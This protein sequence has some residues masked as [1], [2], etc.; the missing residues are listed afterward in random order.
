MSKYYH[1][2]NKFDFEVALYPSLGAIAEFEDLRGKN[3]LESMAIDR[4]NT[5]DIFTLLYQCHVVASQRMKENIKVSLNDMIETMTYL[6]G[7]EMIDLMSEDL[8]K[9]YGIDLK[10]EEP[11]KKT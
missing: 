7:R 9:C 5:K 6:D 4:P 2:K 8:L 3:F 11:Q 10:K 1:I